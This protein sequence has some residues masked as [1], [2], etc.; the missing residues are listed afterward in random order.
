[1][2][3]NNSSQGCAPLFIDWSTMI[4]MLFSRYRIMDNVFHI[5]LAQLAPH[6]QT[7]NTTPINTMKWSLATLRGSSKGI[8]LSSRPE[9][10]DNHEVYRWSGRF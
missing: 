7:Q 4:Q 6:P 3:I 9:E 10:D 5:V 8:L 2:A 1:M